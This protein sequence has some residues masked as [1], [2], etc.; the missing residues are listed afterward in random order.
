MA[1]VDEVPLLATGARL[2]GPDGV[3]VD[4][5]GSAYSDVRGLALG[6]HGDVGRHAGVGPVARQQDC[7]GA[8]ASASFQGHVQSLGGRG[9]GHLKHH[10]EN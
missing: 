2:L 10:N 9:C 3:A 6:G 8:P 4:R 7:D 5:V 1:E